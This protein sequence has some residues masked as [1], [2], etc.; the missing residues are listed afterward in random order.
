MALNDP[1]VP[2][3]AEM[4]RASQDVGAPAVRQSGEEGQTVMHWG[5]GGAANAM[6]V[7]REQP[8]I[9]EGQGEDGL[10]GEEEDGVRRGSTEKPRGGS[11]AEGMQTLSR[12]TTRETARSPAQKQQQQEKSQ[13]PRPRLSPTGRSGSIVDAGRGILNRLRS[14]SAKR[15]T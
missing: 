3:H 11:A 13:S 9:I 8:K 7:E 10:D 5:R 14:P 4:A 2:A 12:Q 15:N 1:T 6:K